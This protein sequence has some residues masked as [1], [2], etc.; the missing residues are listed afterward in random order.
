MDPIFLIVMGAILALSLVGYFL[1]QK[2]YKK[3]EEGLSQADKDRLAAAEITVTNPTTKEWTQ[4]AW[5][6]Q[7]LDKG[8]SYTVRLI[9]HNKTNKSQDFNKLTVV[10][11]GIPK[12][13]ADAH[14]LKVGSFVT[15]RRS[16]EKGTCEILF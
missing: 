15:M 2:K 1:L 3:L 8:E 7:M 16:F 11:T 9:Y 6:A 13:E 14:G 5:V 12:A 10:T 4:E